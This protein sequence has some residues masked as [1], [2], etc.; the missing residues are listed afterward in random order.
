MRLFAMLGATMLDG[1]GG[2]GDPAMG[3]FQTWGHVRCR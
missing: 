2:T 1:F 3:A